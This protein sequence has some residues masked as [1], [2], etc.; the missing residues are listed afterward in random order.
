M[1]HVETELVGRCRLCLEVERGFKLVLGVQLGGTGDE[2]GGRKG[3][4]FEES[5][6]PIEDILGE[7]KDKILYI[8]SICAI[9]VLR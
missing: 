8:P 1:V 5:E 4:V 3:E 6:G 2:I 9:F 7:R